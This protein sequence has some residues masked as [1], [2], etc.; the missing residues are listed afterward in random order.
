MKSKGLLL[1]LLCASTGALLEAKSQSTS[2]SQPMCTRASCATDPNCECYCSVKCAPRQKDDEDRP[3]FANKDYNANSVPAQCYCKENDL[4]EY[5]RQCSASANNRIMNR[6]KNRR[7][8]RR[9]TRTVKTYKTQ[10]N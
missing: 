3:V 2:Y 9:T 5:N 8:N 6:R 4:D 10:S 1:A 7:A